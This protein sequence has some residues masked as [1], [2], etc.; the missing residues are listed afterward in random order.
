[1]K[2]ERQFEHIENKI[3]EA[4]Q[5]ILVDFNGKSWVKMK[6]LLDKEDKKKPFIWLWFLLPLVMLM[7]VGIYGLRNNK[8]Q[9][10]QTKNDSNTIIAKEK[11]VPIQNLT[12]EKKDV[13]KNVMKT[14]ADNTL[15]DKITGIDNVKNNIT[16]SKFQ[17][18]NAISV[19]IVK[20]SNK[21]ADVA[22]QNDP[23]D[24]NKNYSKK[25]KEKTRTKA[26][27]KASTAAENDMGIEA[28]N[29]IANTDTIKQDA[30]IVQQKIVEKDNTIKKDST[31]TNATPIA[32]NKKK[33]KEKLVSKF[34]VLGV[35][36]GDIGSVKLLTFNKSSIAAK[37][38]IG[39]G[40]DISKKLS[41]QSGIY[42]SNKKYSGGQGDYTAKTGTYLSTVAITKV[43]ALCLIYEVPISIRYRFLQNKHYSFF[44][45]TGASSYIMK[46]EDYNYFYRRYNM[47][48]SKF[49]SYSGNQHLFST[50]TVSIGAEKYLSKQF[51][52]QIEPVF[53]VPLYGV[54]EGSVKLFSTSLQLG[55]KYRPFK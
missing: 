4:A 50:A 36:G 33:K 51:S 6:A 27:I 55:L 1:M 31:I 49:Y 28:N 48:Y 45:T 29:H 20:G 34:Y 3:R 46:K 12:N 16:Q 35:L 18:Q 14:N 54:G 47:P 9:S 8:I 40:F 30:Q 7:A 2:S 13:V 17:K 43:D 24:L 23:Y 53:S 5:N 21:I 11:F 15:T 10:A 25:Y 32:K 26:N 41:V 42:I 52:I 38:G 44:A 19:S 37:Y 22:I 39:L